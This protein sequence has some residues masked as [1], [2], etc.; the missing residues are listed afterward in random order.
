VIVV[1]DMVAQLLQEAA[2][3]EGITLVA[4]LEQIAGREYEIQQIEGAK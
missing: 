2:E 3:R 4:M 1:D